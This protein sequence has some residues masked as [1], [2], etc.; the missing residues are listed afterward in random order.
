MMTKDLQ[1]YYEARFDMFGTKGWK[2]LIEDIGQVLSSSKDINTVNN[3]QQ[4]WF[5]KGQLDI[6]QWLVSMP[7][8]TED[9]FKNL[10]EDSNEVHA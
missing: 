6:L 3:E 10:T 5:R 7:N 4:L 8:I 1:A 9:A 2:D